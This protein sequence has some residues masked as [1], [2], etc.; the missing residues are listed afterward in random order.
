MR[1]LVV[2]CLFVL[3]GCG[4]GTSYVKSETTLG[5]VVVYRNGV[6]YFE[7]FAR[8][9]EDTLSLSVPA[10][11]VDDFLKSLTVVDAKTGKPAPIAYPTSPQAADPATGLIDMNITLQGAGPH[12]LK[13]SY[14][15]EAPSW[16]PSYRIVIGK[17]GKVNVQAWAI[18]DNTSGEDWKSVK[19]GVGSSSALSF[20]FDLRSVRTVQRETL[21][22]DDLFAVAPPTGGASHGRD[23]SGA[24]KPVVV[25]LTDASPELAKRD[26]DG[27]YE[28]DGAKVSAAEVIVTGKSSGG[29]RAQSFS[30]PQRQT[31]NAPRYKAPASPP[32]PAYGPATKPT[33]SKPQAGYGGQVQ[34]NVDQQQSQQQGQG[35]INTMAQK[36][37]QTRGQ[38]VVEG[39]ADKN[40]QDKFASSLERANRVREQLIRNGVS[41]EQVV[42]VGNGERAGRPGG[43][44]IVEATPAGAREPTKGKPEP[45]PDAPAGALP[46]EPIGTSHFESQTPMDVPRGTS[47]MVSILH[48]DTN[49]EVVFFYDPESAR[50]NTAFPFRAV[51]IKNPTDSV[52]ESGPV[53][54]F[55]AGKFIGEGLCDPI[56][57][58]SIAFVPFALDRQ[59]VVDKDE[60]ERDEIARI[61]S[62]QRGVF[63]TE[64]QHTRRIKLTLNNRLDERAT[65]YIRHTVAKGYKLGKA[66][67][68]RERLGAAHLF[69]VD[70]G[71]NGK[72]E[73]VIEEST[74]LFKSTDIRSPEGVGLVKVFL[75]SAAAEGPLKSAVSEL[76]RLQTEIGN[77]EQQIGTVREQM[78]EYRARMDELHVQIVTLKAVKTSGTSLMQH[79]EKKLTEVSEKLSKATVDL[80]GVQEKLMV[81]RIRFQDGVAELSLEKKPDATDPAAPAKPA[82]KI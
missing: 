40:D 55:G 75:S 24:E 68:E 41:P 67:T 25:E 52:L 57:A 80:V 5:R 38:V 61:I 12:E 63:A 62:V 44:R 30:A 48:T 46:A 29:G 34:G 53:T 73:V 35:N 31:G 81:A 9:E 49:G 19:L 33:E 76:L 32:K 37:R 2:P 18:V 27:T 47:A 39:Y 51:R 23:P 65:V 64:V 3:A 1:T 59:I 10:D 6:A 43:V 7:R 4:G 71:P 17:D 78:Q 72:S 28:L 82:T 8:V 56:P 74:P 77:L 22:S 21:K 54:V 16:K 69:R 26:G 50:G 20:R 14:V 58:R 79:L 42:A 60:V 45:T 13:L 36:L 15:S 66:P 70:V 11:K